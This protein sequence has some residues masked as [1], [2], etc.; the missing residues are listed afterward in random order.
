MHVVKDK[1][2]KV[3]ALSLITTSYNIHM[4]DNSKQLEKMD[5]KTVSLIAQ[6]MQEDGK[7][8]LAVS[9]VAGG[10]DKKA[11]ASDKQP[12]GLRK[13]GVIQVIKDKDD[14]VI[15]LNLSVGS[16]KIKMDNNSKQLETMN[17]KKVNLICQLMQEDDK[18]VL[19]VSKVEGGEES[20][21]ATNLPPTS[22]DQP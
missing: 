5:G 13:T 4:D 15:A 11:S 21:N 20:G 3:I 16:Y 7:R 12:S 10:A 17:G 9:K 2:G 6:V 19:A 18:T 14:K 22:S 1:K 8:V